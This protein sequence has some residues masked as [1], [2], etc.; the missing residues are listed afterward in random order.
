MQRDSRHLRAVILDPRS[1]KPEQ[2]A[3]AP[4]EDLTSPSWA[5]D[6]SLI[7]V[8]SR[9]QTSLWRFRRLAE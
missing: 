8:G 9:I 5:P 1:G 2:I 6:G 7:A 3:L 4:E